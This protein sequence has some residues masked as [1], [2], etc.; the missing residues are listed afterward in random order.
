MYEYLP[1]LTIVSYSTGFSFPIIRLPCMPHRSQMRL[2]RLIVWLEEWKVV[3]G[4]NGKLLEGRLGRVLLYCSQPSHKFQHPPSNT[5]PV[6]LGS[7]HGHPPSNTSPVWLGSL[8]GHP[9]SNTSPVWLGSLHG[10]PPSNTS[11]V[12]LGSLRG[13]P[14]SNSAN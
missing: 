14:P 2:V 4:K 1:F 8:H 3:G 7:L 12:W 5:S 13:H 10:H 9:P 11:P 6:W